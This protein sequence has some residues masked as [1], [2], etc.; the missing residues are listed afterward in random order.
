M[1]NVLN[2]RQYTHDSLNSATHHGKLLTRI[3]VQCPCPSFRH[4]QSSWP[5]DIA[6]DDRQWLVAEIAGLL[7][8]WWASCYIL[9]S[10]PPPPFCCV[11]NNLQG[12]ETTFRSSI[13]FLFFPHITICGQ[14]FIGQT[15]EAEQVHGVAGDKVIHCAWM[16]RVQ[17]NFWPFGGFF[18]LQLSRGPP[19]IVI[20]DRKQQ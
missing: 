9:I 6:D 18:F 2:V 8:L 3:F 20:R 1:R 11:S 10:V 16:E 15:K 19:P 14:K 4:R 13:A 5:P 12:A 17:W 7:C